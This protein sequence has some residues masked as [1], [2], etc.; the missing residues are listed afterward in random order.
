MIDR[1]K[2]LER[3]ILI[4]DLLI[5][6]FLGIILNI[7]VIIFNGN[8]M[9][10]L[11]YEEMSV[12]DDYIRFSEFNQVNYGWLGDVFHIKSLYFSIGDVLV[13]GGILVIILIFIHNLYL[14][15][16]EKKWHY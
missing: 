10:I 15:F 2:Q 7:S 6:V 3:R 16:K 12:P 13:F 11:A 1:I 4:N 8:R 5:L 14:N 9:P